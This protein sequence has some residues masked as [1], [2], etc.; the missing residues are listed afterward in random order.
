MII[1]SFFNSK[2]EMIRTLFLLCSEVSLPLSKR[3]EYMGV[4]KTPD[5]VIQLID[6]IIFTRINLLVTRNK[7]V[8]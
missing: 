6:L 5:H 2:L 8:C 4:Y 1:L 7:T 3:V